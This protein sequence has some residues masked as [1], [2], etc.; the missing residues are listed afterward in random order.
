[1]KLV[2]KGG[3][4]LVVK[5][6]TI[7]VFFLL[8]FIPISVFSLT[9]EVMFDITCDLTNYAPYYDCSTPL[10]LIVFDMRYPLEWDYKTNEWYE[11]NFTNGL[12]YGMAYW[13]QYVPAELNNGT[14]SNI[15][16]MI[17]LGNTYNQTGI[18]KY[19]AEENLTPL[20]HEI[21]HITCK[22]RWHPERGDNNE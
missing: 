18:G 15:F 3:R 19:D 14:Q 22:C 7:S 11:Q 21:K 5:L 1:M 16:S 6:G 2:E 12:S 4:N 13:N 17:V 10:V 20:T 8:L 9:E